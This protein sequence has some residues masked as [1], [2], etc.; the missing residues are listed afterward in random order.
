MIW[1]NKN[2][3]I[4]LSEI[5][6]SYTCS[7]GPG[8]QNVNKVATKVLLRWNVQNSSAL[9]QGVKHRFLEQQENRI[10]KEGELILTSQAT[11]DQE[12]NR[13]DCLDKLRQMVL[14][15]SI[16]PTPRKKTKPTRAS[17]ER[18]L[19]NKKRRSQVK[20]HRRSPAED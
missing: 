15:A 4:D 17:R 13:Q 7:G 2:I 18:R 19:A 11:R 6:W 8:G 16:V 14:R 1:I 12:R 3:Q 5:E 9:P 20:A 10:T